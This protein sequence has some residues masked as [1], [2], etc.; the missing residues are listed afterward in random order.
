MVYI[1][2]NLMGTIKDY[3]PKN[4][5]INQEYKKYNNNYI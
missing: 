2:F 5:F 3:G 1:Y 4:A